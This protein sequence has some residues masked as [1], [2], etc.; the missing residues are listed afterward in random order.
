MKA[1]GDETHGAVDPA[2]SGAHWGFVHDL[3][4]V[5]PLMRPHWRLVLASYL[6]TGF[7]ALAALLAPWPVAIVINEVSGHQTGGLFGQLFAGASQTTVLVV[8]IAGGF[9]LTALQYGVGVISEYCTTKL[10]SSMTLDLRSSLFEH[11]QQLSQGFHD[12][13]RTGAMIYTINNAAEAAGQVA[14]AFPPLFQAVLTLIGMLVIAIGIDP[15]LALLSLTVVPFVYASTGYYTNRIEP[16]LYRVR[17]IEHN[18]LNVV[19]EAVKMLRVIVAF[20]REQHEYA[21]FRT[22]AEEALDA[23]VSLTV[24]QTVFS[25]AVSLITAAGTAL[26]LGVGAWHVIEG[27]LSPGGLLVMMSYVAEVYL[28]LRSVSSTMTV[29]Q[30]QVVS[31]RMALRLLNEPPGILE[32]PGAISLPPVRGRVTYRDVSFGYARRML[33]VDGVSFDVTPG[34]RIGI[35]GPTGAGKSTL[36]NLMPRFVDP[37]SGS[38]LIDGYDVR[39]LTL[40]CVRHAISIVH[41]DT[42]LFSG[43]IAYNIRYGRL[44]ASDEEIVAAARAAEIHDFI[45]SLPGGYET[46]LG[47]Q[48]RQLSGG[49]RQRLAIARAFL[50]DAPILILDEPT[51]SLDSRTESAILNALDSLMADRTTFLVA[52]RLSTLRGVDRVLV[53]DRGRLVEQ[54]APDELLA[55]GGLFAS[56][57]A[58]QL[59]DWPIAMAGTMS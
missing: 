37:Q 21:R 2:A 54:G 14:V 41:Q 22:W 26:V 27:K 47:E 4:K 46:E 42:M 10:A 28:P 6:T 39:E 7:G 23:R 40:D 20:R 57:H 19:Y 52:H 35:V 58:A 43:T 30:D 13:T 12:E 11:A 24:R 38:V 49:E 15:V 50:K 29:L 59:V 5:L 8:V 45:R 31:L 25:M 17:N 44:E 3:P 51:A 9:L 36:M 53:L 56:L 18:S 34:E 48:G 32:P 55:S 33:A 1:F 16:Q